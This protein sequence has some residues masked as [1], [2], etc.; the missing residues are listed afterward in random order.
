MEKNKLLKVIIDNKLGKELAQLLYD[1]K[2]EQANKIMD[3]VKKTPTFTKL[4][5]IEWIEK[6]CLS[7]KSIKIKPKQR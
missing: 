7:L 6:H 4:N 2:E 1:T 3:F 5:L